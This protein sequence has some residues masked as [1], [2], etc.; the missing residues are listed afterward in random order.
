MISTKFGNPAAERFISLEA[1]QIEDELEPQ[2]ESSSAI[3]AFQE[4]KDL[5]LTTH[6]VR[7]Y[8][9]LYREKKTNR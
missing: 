3:S 7:P 1:M 4:C 9:A 2:G 6:E 5:V 8:A